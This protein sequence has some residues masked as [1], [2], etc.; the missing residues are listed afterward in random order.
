[1]DNK[2][3]CDFKPENNQIRLTLEED[4]SGASGLC[5]EDTLEEGKER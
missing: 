4:H 1:M 2:E 5:G 3:Q